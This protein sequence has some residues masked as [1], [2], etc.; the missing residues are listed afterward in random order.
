MSRQ[1]TRIFLAALA[2]LRGGATALAASPDLASAEALLEDGECDAGD[3][4]CAL[5]A[6]QLRG[7]QLS[8]DADADEGAVDTNT[9]SRRRKQDPTDL[10]WNWTKRIYSWIAY[11]DANVTAAELK[12]KYLNADIQSVNE[13]LLHMKDPDVKLA[14]N[15]T[16]VN[17][18]QHPNS[19]L[20]KPKGPPGMPGRLPGMPIPMAVKPA[21]KVEDLYSYHEPDGQGPKA[22][23]E[24]TS[25]LETEADE[26]EIEDFFEGLTERLR[27][28]EDEDEDEE[29]ETASRRRKF[30]K[31]TIPPRVHRMTQLL[32]KQQQRIN[33]IGKTI[34]EVEMKIDKVDFFMTKHPHHYKIPTNHKPWWK[35]GPAVLLEDE[36]EEQAASHPHPPPVDLDE[37]QP[38]DMLVRQIAKAIDSTSELWAYQMGKLGSSVEA[39]RTRMNIYR[40]PGIVENR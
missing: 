6:L 20:P 1:T 4:E 8:T 12:L 23:P 18:T 24:A 37:P 28:H 40:G 13:T 19:W 30:E 2:V 15:W 29:T 36:A 31:V 3:A 38:Q 25:L 34:A 33:T 10:S 5:S 27:E 21:G 22:G 39:V 7:T 11:L 16:E 14:I 32:I 17:W 26:E 35:A 9:M